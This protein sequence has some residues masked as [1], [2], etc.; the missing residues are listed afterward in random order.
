MDPSLFTEGRNC[1]RATAASCA[2][3]VVDCANY[4][5]DL[6]QSICRARHSIFVLGWDIDSRIELLRGD[7]VR[8]RRYPT[9]FF[10]LIQ[11]KAAE[12]PQLMIYLN[13]WNYSLLFAQERESFSEFRWRSRSP[14]N[15]HFCLD[16]AI[17]NGGCHHQKVIVIDDEV[18]YCGGM[19]IALGRWDFRDH[20][21]WNARRIDPG[22]G[23]HAHDRVSF[24]PYHDV[25]LAVAGEAATAL[26]ELA[27]E[28]WRVAAGYDPIP[29]RKP[30]GVTPPPAWPPA[31]P[32]DFR[33]VPSAISLTMP[34]LL[35]AP[36]LR[37]AERMYIDLVGAAENMI[38]IE[39]QFLT[40]E[41]VAEAINKRLHEKPEL[42]ALLVSCD[43]PH[44]YM[45]K[46]A[47]WTARAQFRDIIEKGGVADRVAIATPMSVEDGESAPVRIHSKIMIVD[48]R[49]LRV[50]SS[51]L[52]T[53]AM[54]LDTEC[55][56]I[57]EARDAAT[58]ARIADI[59]NDLIGE[60]TGLQAQEIAGIVN[61]GGAVDAFLRFNG[62]SG[63]HLIRVNDEQFREEMGSKLARS[64]ADPARPFIPAEL[65][66]P[67]H[68]PGTRRHWTVWLFSALPAVLLI[69][70]LALMW[71]TTSISAYVNPAKLAPLMDRLGTSPGSLLAIT[72]LMFVAEFFLFPLVIINAAAAAAFGPAV[73]FAM[74]MAAAMATAA[75][76]FGAGKLLG[77]RWL[78]LVT[79]SVVDRVANYIRRGGVLSIVILRTIPVAPFNAV[80]L[81]L[82]ISS[83]SFS[84]YMLGT[85]LGI[86]PGTLVTAFTGHSLAQFWRHPD[87]GSL[88]LLA[89]AALCWIMVV[90]II[91][92]LVRRWQDMYFMRREP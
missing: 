26:A 2:T 57:I 34:S 82:G 10:D 45:E 66:I 39:N 79:G 44:G 64:M 22:G 63:H 78:R 47:M 67:H 55:D 60:H 25:Q 1:W 6:Y 21:A 85:F 62:N 49:Y 83:A 68:Y 29:L 80:N 90:T 52:T 9:N 56:M 38:Y 24:G 77:L 16:S 81:G 84:D 20:H 61:G 86:A 53:R 5:R 70:G 59:R 13:R 43:L 27:R 7:D 71:E 46:K 37:Q 65:T 88:T 41:P 42:R 4:Y 76:G 14:E 28:R 72:G 8:G 75:L 23:F 48:D 35:G 17:P 74:S 87:V 36:P 18:A 19:D 50:G 32:P 40:F 33:D 92:F 31:D 89:M 12:N 91:H 54:R 15:I 3:V 58:R 73:G 51:N 30:A 69:L 11:A